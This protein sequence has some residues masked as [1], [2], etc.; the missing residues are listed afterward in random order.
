MSAVKR[1]P[2]DP[3]IRVAPIALDGGPLSVGSAVAE[4]CA[5]VARSS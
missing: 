3:A 2:T 1:L 5:A 4:M